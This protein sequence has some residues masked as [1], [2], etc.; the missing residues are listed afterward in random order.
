[1]SK[2]KILF[3]APS[4]YNYHS[5]IKEEMERQGYE[6]LYIKDEPISIYYKY[7]KKTPFKQYMINKYWEEIYN[8]DFENVHKIFVI[9]G[10]TLNS[11]IVEKFFKKY[12]K[13][14]KVYYLWDS[15][16]NTPSYSSIYKYFDKVYSFDYLDSKE[17]NH[18]EYL[19]LFYPNILKNKNK[20]IKYDV[21]FV[22]SAHG[23]RLEVLAK[24]MK[25]FS[26][27]NVEFHYYIYISQI[28]K[29]NYILKKDPNYFLLRNFIHTTPLSYESVQ[30]IFNNSKAIL[31]INNVNQSGL[32]IRTFET[33]ISNKQMITTNK[34]IKEHDFYSN[35][36]IL[37]IDRDDIIID[38]KFFSK[39]INYSDLEKYSISSWIKEILFEK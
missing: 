26:K 29:I 19:P 14:K 22:G 18:L 10:E 9:R 23:D 25:L 36:S 3:I 35:K 32:T 37:I 5:L 4:F 28:Q 2:G 1:M 11:N 24:C 6:V 20:K 12:E 7:I 13:S 34:Y 17:K 8:H 31:D 21:S 27:L 15:I 16:V 30:D 33:L 39:K 38:K